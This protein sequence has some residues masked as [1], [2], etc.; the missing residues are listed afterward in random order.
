MRRLVVSAAHKSSG[1]TTVTL[2]LCRALSMRGHIVQAFKK[3]PDYI[4]PLWHTAA[5]GRA[6][7]NLDFYTQTPLEMRSLFARAAEGAGIALIEGNK[8]LHDGMDIEGSDCTAGLARLLGAPVILVIDTHGMTRGIAPLLLGYQAFAPDVKIAGVVLNQ[9]AGPRHEGKLRQAVERYTDAVVLGAIPRDSALHIAERHLGLI[10]ANEAKGAEAAIERIGQAMARHLD[11]AR[12]LDLADRA[13]PFDLPAAKP[14]PA[15]KPDL[16]IAI[17]RDQA[18][19]FYYEDDIEAFSEAGAELLPFDT[20]RDASLPANIDGVFIGGG[21]PEAHMAAISANRTLLEDLKSKIEQGL[22]AYAECGG[23]MLLARSISWQGSKAS[24]A[25][26]IPGDVVMHERPVGKGYIRLNET[27]DG[28]W[29]GQ[30]A[31]GQAFSG[32]E[33]HHS[34]IENLPGTLRYAYRVERGQGIDGARDGLVMGN[35]TAS[36]AHLRSVGKTLW[37]QRFAAFC[38]SKR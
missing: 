17:A 22:P 24:M 38:R 18:F 30:F 27:G 32:H 5:S 37:V 25:C 7:R 16:R 6:C 23:L 2:G 1:K 11:L 33:F 12:L 8:G 35:L 14:R 15:P 20:M 3:G 13:P 9:I 26:V 10:P 4:D 21:F 28:L 36:Y 31:E 19:G 29:P 34:T